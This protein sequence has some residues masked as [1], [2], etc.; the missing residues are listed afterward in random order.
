MTA[1]RSRGDG[2]LSWDEGRQR[3]VAAVTVGYIP[4]GRRIV[5][6]DAGRTKTQARAK[7]KEILRDHDDGVAISSRAD[8]VAQA[9]EDW[10][11]HGLGGR[12]VSTL[13][14]CRSLARQHV[15]PGPGCAEVAGAVRGGRRP[16]ARGRGADVEHQHGGADQ[17]DPGQ[18]DLP[19]AGA[20][21]G[22]AQHRPAV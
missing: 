20:R 16:L 3:W 10:L 22:Q 2:G 5:R 18:G 4:S 15:I 7:L 13:E 12:D 8:T 9:V 21:Q 14:A 11:A 19:G 17:V 6:R 1:R